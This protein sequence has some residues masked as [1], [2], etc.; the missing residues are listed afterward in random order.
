MACAVN[1]HAGDTGRPPL[2]LSGFGTLDMVHANTDKADY[3]SS[4]IKASGAG[5]SRAW[6]ANV[7]SRLG[8]QLDVLSGQRLSGVLQVVSEQNLDGEYS[9]RVEWANLKYQVTPDLAVRAGRIAL[10][11]F[12][13]ADYRKVGFAYQ[14]VRPPVELYGALP[15]TSSDGIDLTAR[16]ATGE[17]RHTS[18]LFFGSDSRGLTA[19]THLQAR[20][21]AGFSHTIETGPLTARLSALTTELTLDIGEDLFSGLQMSGDQG[22]LLAQRY[23]VDHKRASLASI[24]LSYDPGNWFITAEA[25]HSHTSS[26]LGKT[27]ALYIGGGARAGAFTPYAGYARVRADTPTHDVGLPVVMGRAPL[28]ANLNM[29]LNSLLQTIPAQSTVSVGVRWDVH[30]NVD[31]K[32]QFER[33]TPH[34]GSRGTLINTQPDF[35]S[36]QPVYVTSLALDF[37]F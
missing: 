26:F 33:V 1:A 16:F 11:L 19:T 2:A 14:W 30:A 10:P 15:I 23:A 22:A 37:V 36:G 9:P 13:M 20:R 35:E 3:A 18:Q 21:I 27:S 6:S 5:Y 32:A 25:G 31:L 8:L 24:G 29:G 28:L 4:A 17:V 34:D 7:D 12:L